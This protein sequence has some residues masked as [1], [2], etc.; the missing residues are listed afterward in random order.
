METKEE[1]FCCKS[2][3]F[4]QTNGTHLHQKVNSYGFF[5]DSCIIQHSLFA[6]LVKMEV[7]EIN[8]RWNEHDLDIIVI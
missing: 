2:I 7:L 1:S 6:D 3:K 8:L 4:A 5:I